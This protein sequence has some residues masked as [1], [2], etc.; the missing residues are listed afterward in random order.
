MGLLVNIIHPIVAKVLNKHIVLLHESGFTD[1]GII[2]FRVNHINYLGDFGLGYRLVQSSKWR[3]FSD[4]EHKHVMGLGV[5]A[6]EEY[7][8]ATS[9]T[10]R[11][12]KRKARDPNMFEIFPSVLDRG[13]LMR[14][15]KRDGQNKVWDLCER[16]WPESK[17]PVKN[18]LCFMIED[19]RMSGL[20]IKNDLGRVR[21][22]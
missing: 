21:S 3:A 16:Y 22:M 2:G 4:S 14:V 18:M 19:I 7:N 1:F 6:A 11:A 13:Y 10:S 5:T 17:E 15:G 8:I 9:I 20:G 12:D